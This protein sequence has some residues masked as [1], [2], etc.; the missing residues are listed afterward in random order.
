VKSSLLD[1][2][3]YPPNANHVLDRPSPFP[4]KPAWPTDEASM[5]SCADYSIRYMTDPTDDPRPNVRGTDGADVLLPVPAGQPA[6]PAT[7]APA[8]SP[9]GAT[10]FNA[11]PGDDLVLGSPGADTVLGGPGNDRIDGGA[12]NDGSLEGEAGNDRIRGGPGDDILFGR[13][14]DDE[15]FGGDDADY[16]E[17]G[18]GRDLLV[19][20]RGNDRLVG[21]LD[22]DRLRGGPGNDELVAYDGTR[23]YVDCGPGFD[24]ARVD[25][26]DRV[27]HCEHVIRPGAPHRGRAHSRRS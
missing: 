26:H 23:D 9:D 5:R 12:G 8:G 11:G 18:R 15:L 1:L 10:I 2:G 20:G 17:G 3:V 27:V 13:A 4:E 7:L 24:V 6:N 25:R 19:G 16:L 22:S 21:G 14:G